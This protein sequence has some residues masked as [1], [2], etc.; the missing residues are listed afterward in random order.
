M[1]FSELL[2]DADAA[3]LEHL[4]GSEVVVYRRGDGVRTTIQGIFEA[5]HQTVSMGV[6]GISGFAPTIF[7]RLSDLSSDPRE[8][9]DATFIVDGKR[10]SARDVQRDGRGFALVMLEFSEEDT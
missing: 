7:V 4:A 2:A 3:T 5:K 9:S 6:D 10:Y 1:S 8:D